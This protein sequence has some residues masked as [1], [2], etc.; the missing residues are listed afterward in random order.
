MRG[1]SLRSLPAIL[2]FLPR[3]P[4]WVRRSE[5]LGGGGGLGIQDS[6]AACRSFR[7]EFPLLT[8]TRGD[9]KFQ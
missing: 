2:A 6:D 4:D 3:F 8:A 1:L 5:T 9:G 7:G